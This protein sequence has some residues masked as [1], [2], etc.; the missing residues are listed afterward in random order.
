VRAFEQVQAQCEFWKNA[1]T[2]ASGLRV[3]KPLGDFLILDALRASG[4]AAIAVSDEKRSMPASRWHRSKGSSRHPKVR[5]ALR[6][7][8]S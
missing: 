4:G 1:W 6:R 8:P 7:C 3:P 5:P 2:V